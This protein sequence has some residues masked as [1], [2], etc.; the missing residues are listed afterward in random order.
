KEESLDDLFDARGGAG[1]IQH[2]KTAAVNRFNAA[3]DDGVNQAVFRLKVIVDGR[4]IDLRFGRDVPQGGTIET[5]HPKELFGSIEDSGFGVEWVGG[6]RR[7]H[8]FV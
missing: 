8:T 2:L 7:D 1:G 5:I 3:L 6:G 4:Q